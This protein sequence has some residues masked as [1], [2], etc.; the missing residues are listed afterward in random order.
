MCRQGAG[1]DRPEGVVWP[2]VPCWSGTSLGCPAREPGC[3]VLGV[4]AR[5]TIFCPWAPVE[6]AELEAVGTQ[7]FS[8]GGPVWVL[9]WVWL[10]RLARLVEAGR[11]GCHE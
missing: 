2:P 10:V 9:A 5:A 8:P 11:W 7:R 4:C 6:G 3:G 1:L